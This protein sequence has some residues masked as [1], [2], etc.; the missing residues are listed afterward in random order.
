[1]TFWWRPKTEPLDLSCLAPF[2]YTPPPPV[3]YQRVTVSVDHRLYMYDAVHMATDHEWVR[4]IS[5][6]SG[7]TLALFARERVT[8]VELLQGE[9]GGPAPPA[10]VERK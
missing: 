8:S 2:L 10:A 7:R 4:I 1:M 3:V 5:A 9:S 6:A